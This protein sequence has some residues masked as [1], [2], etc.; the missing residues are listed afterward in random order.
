VGH[1]CDTVARNVDDGLQGKEWENS[2]HVTT[3]ARG[4]ARNVG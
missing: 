1:T 4:L 2:F 3:N